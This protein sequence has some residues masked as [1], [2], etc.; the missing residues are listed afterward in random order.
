MNQYHVVAFLKN[1]ASSEPLGDFFCFGF[2]LSSLSELLAIGESKC[3]YFVLY[4]NH[5]PCL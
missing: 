2:S 4:S 1:A 5:Q 3:C